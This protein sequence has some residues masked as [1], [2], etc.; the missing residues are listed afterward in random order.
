MSKVDLHVHTTASD[1]QYAPAD[2][3]RLALE[4]GIRVLA[5]T[6]HDTVA[7]VPEALAAAS[8]TPLEVIPG[9]EMSTETHHGEVHILGY[10]V[11]IEEAR[12]LA[13]LDRLR[14]ARR[15]RAQHMVE[16]LAK[17]GVHVPWQRVADLVGAGAY[18][19][20]HIARILVELGYVPNTHDA[21]AQYIG[22]H[23][24][25]YVARYKLTPAEAI[26]A[27]AR[28][29]GVPVLAHPWGIEDLGGVVADLVAEGLAG[30][31]VYYRG[32]TPEMMQELVNLARKHGLAATGGSDFHGA[33][34]VA[35]V[36]LGSVDVPL[37]AVEELRARR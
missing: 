27:I 28:A 30:I 18:G 20:P 25:A 8:G 26:H 34:I 7:G 31:E 9:V 5:I 16:R 37:W 12:F 36:E 4:R 21:F 24:P 33:Q 3:V 2:V 13:L 6:D 1:G 19:R 11:D 29:G 15:V 22:Y 14:D 10:Y 17:L 23:G 32:Y 35:G